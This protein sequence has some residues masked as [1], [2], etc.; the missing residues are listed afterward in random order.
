MS[1]FLPGTFSHVCSLNRLSRHQPPITCHLKSHFLRGDSACSSHSLL[2]APAPRS[3]PYGTWTPS[4]LHLAQ[5]SHPDHCNE[6]FAGLS[7]SSMELSVHINCQQPASRAGERQSQSNHL[8]HPHAY[9][10]EDTLK[11]VLCYKFGEGAHL[12]VVKLLLV[13]NSGISP[14]EFKISYRC[15]GSRLA[16]CNLICDLSDSMMKPELSQN[17]TEG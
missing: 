17:E 1:F 4:S 7:A 16:T 2:Q 9:K 8:K 10:Q 15:Q 14:G 3:H 11:G 6:Q 5:V 13:L 12:V